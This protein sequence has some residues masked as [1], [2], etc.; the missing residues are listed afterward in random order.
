MKRPRNKKKR[1]QII[2]LGDPNQGR[3]KIEAEIFKQQNPIVITA[4]FF[5]IDRASQNQSFL[6]DIQ[7][8]EF[9][10]FILDV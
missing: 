10:L 4:V 6:L 3:L 1:N 9:H 5:D 2:Y 8:I 7:N